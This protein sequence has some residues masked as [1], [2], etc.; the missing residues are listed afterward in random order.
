MSDFLKENPRLEIEFLPPYAPNL[1]LIE[2]LWGFAKKK[3]V[4]ICQEKPELDQN[5]C[6]RNNM[7]LLQQSFLCLPKVLQR[8]FGISLRFI[9]KIRIIHWGF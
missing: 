9:F 3:P 4:K 7:R 2:R 6:K 1:N 8:G 5:I